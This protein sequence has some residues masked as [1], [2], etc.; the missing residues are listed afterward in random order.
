VE[1]R[2]L[3]PY[4][5]DDYWTNSVSGGVQIYKGAPVRIYLVADVEAALKYWQTC[6]N[7]GEA[8]DRPG[9]CAKAI[10]EREKGLEAMHEQTMQRAEQAESALDAMTRER[11]AL[12]EEK[13]QLAAD[14]TRAVY[15]RDEA[16]EQANTNYREVQRLRAD[17]SALREAH[18]ELTADA[19]WMLDFVE[20]QMRD[21]HLRD[22]DPFETCSSEECVRVRRLRAALS[23]QPS[24]DHK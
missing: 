8:M 24:E 23:R 17:L 11:A 3:T 14:Y 2:P 1:G 19:L 16:E 15:E 6:A 12:K 20:V 4:Y 9:V 18:T 22:S 7:C 13:L 5:C 21:Q 10:S